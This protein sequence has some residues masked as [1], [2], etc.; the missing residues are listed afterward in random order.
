[1]QQCNTTPDG[2]IIVSLHLA[3][4]AIDAMRE[5]K[6]LGDDATDE[7]SITRAVAWML[8]TAYK[9]GIKAPEP[10]QEPEPKAEEPAKEAAKT[11]GAPAK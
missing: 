4:L 1:M 3:K 11:E 6:F 8:G 2:S 10:A 7:A 9:A 5:R